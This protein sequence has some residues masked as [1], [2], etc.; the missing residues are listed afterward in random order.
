MPSFL[1]PKD[2]TQE[3][4][5]VLVIAMLLGNLVMIVMYLYENCIVWISNIARKVRVK[6]FSFSMEMVQN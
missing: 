2:I 6:R 4:Q 1:R 3:V 5:E